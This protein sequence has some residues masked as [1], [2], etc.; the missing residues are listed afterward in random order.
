M[1]AELKAQVAFHLTGK[2]AAGALDAVEALHLRPALL[3][4][5]RDLSAL[6]YDYPLVLA[7][8][9]A[10]GKAIHSLT[11]I[12]NGLMRELASQGS[13]G[14]KLRKHLIRLE[15]EIR[16]LRASGAHGW[17]SV[18]WTAAASRLAQ[19]D[20]D[21]AASLDRARALLT[22]DGDVVDCDDALPGDLL[23]HAWLSAQ[24]LKT[25]AFRRIVNRLIQRL[26]D[27]LRSD[28]VHSEEGQ[29]AKSLQAAVGGGHAEIFDF[30][31]MSRLLGK[32]LPRHPLPQGRR[33]R[34]EW[35][36]STLRSQRFFDLP[37]R[38]DERRQPVR[39]H[40]FVFETCAGAMKAYRERLPDM[41]A[42]AKALALAE[43][44]IEGLYVEAQHDAFFRDYS[45][46]ML[47]AGDLA[48]FPDYLIR[49][50]GDS[51]QPAEHERLN[52]ILAAPLPMKILVQSDDL[53]DIVSVTGTRP[54][55]SM[56]DLQYSRYAME[57]NMAYVVQAPASHLYQY[58]ER[59][60]AAMKHVG[61]ALFNVYSGMAGGTTALPPYLNAAAA[62]TSRAFP[63]FVYDPAAGDNLAARF[64][65]D[66]NPDADA[67]WP[68]QALACE[69]DNHQTVRQEVAFTFVDFVACDPR[70]S[71]HFAR[72]PHKQWNDQMI[73]VAAAIAATARRSETNV[74][75]LLVTDEDNRLHRV[76]ADDKLIREARRC[77][78]MWHG[79]QEMGGIHNSH[80]DR[81]LAR[82]KDAWLAQQQAAAPAAVVAEST[83]P[84]AATPPAESAAVAETRSS[85]DAYIE[86]PRC[87]TCNEC[88]ELNP[89]MFAYD[90]NK[91][92]YIA[93]IKAGTY[94]ELVEAAESCQV[95]VIH[96]GKPRDPN[97]PGLEELVK[98]A[99]AFL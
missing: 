60:A 25:A 30:E 65:L 29:T 87:S 79:L 49:L 23:H 71:G 93:D 56:R 38:H 96:P 10:G 51:L 4:P 59:V 86:T 34:L 98:R 15:R 42:L 13:E 58:R 81:L 53:L 89:R 97:E 32:A 40:N 44:E 63:T 57:C 46:D 8:G 54:A 67:D 17:L 14:E 77:R 11:A 48:V 1:H 31:M 28:F 9:T 20:P 61:P 72:V 70:Y 66:D 73:P 83:Q 80:A 5:Y 22:V 45:A 76:I 91:Q 47:D 84:A 33:A 16:I 2:R 88:I 26:A 62:L 18:L 68:V 41:V 52:E 74:P 94:R 43:L 35:A 85:D 39:P 37:E 75:Y 95:S 90:G 82:E 69:D 24:E 99:E 64:D 6:R 55:F 36:L 92:A 12:M 78:E 27:I 21:I 7:Q 19:A 3:A 50:R